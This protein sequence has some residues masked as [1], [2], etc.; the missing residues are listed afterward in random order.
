MNKKET[1]KVLSVKELFHAL[2]FSILSIAFLFFL[3]H[4]PLNQLFIDPFSEAIK[5]HD[6]MDVAIS[7]FRNHDDPKLFDNNIIIINSKFTNRKDI[8]TSVN[9]LLNKNVGAIGVDLIFDTLHQTA[10]D[11]L[12]ANALGNK[13][14][15][16][17]YTFFEHKD[18]RQPSFSGITSSPFFTNKSR[19]GYVNL[20]SNDGFTVRAFEPFH[21]VNGRQVKSFALQLASII[22]PEIESI[23]KKRNNELEWINFKRVQPGSINMIPPINSNK[24]IHYAYSGINEFLN[25]T[26]SYP[27]DYFINKI[28][29]IGFNGETQQAMSMKDRYYTPLNENYQGRSIPDMHGV[30]VHANIISM[31]LSKDFIE[32]VPELY[33]Y[34]MSFFLFFINYLCFTK[35]ARRKLFFMLPTVRVFQLIQFVVLFAGAILFLAIGNIK[36]GFILVITSV[37]LSYELFEFYAHKLRNRIAQR[38]NNLV[39]KDEP[40][41]ENSAEGEG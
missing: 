27:P 17:G 25:D 10:E 36:F 23:T 1:N 30:T 6:V 4:L 9:F 19:Q 33:L 16:I 5:N 34:L 18:I 3:H 21:I 38:I 35:M 31:L 13:K 41:H 32:E 15:V 2:I 26:S 29:L 24:A 28:V 8:A 11:T 14:V 20:A 22:D 39:E 40:L 37:I 7:K 12:L